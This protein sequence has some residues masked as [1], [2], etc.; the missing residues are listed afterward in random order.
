[1]ADVLGKRNSDDSG[2]NNIPKPPVP[3]NQR[4]PIT[5]FWSLVDQLL[6]EGVTREIIAFWLL[7]LLTMVLCAA[8]HM[9][10][11]AHT[12]VATSVATGTTPPVT[13]YSFEEIKQFLQLVLTPLI[14]L[15]SAATGFYFGSQSVK[16]SATPP[17]TAPVTA[18]A[19]PPATAT[20]TV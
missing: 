8:F 14:T 19:P 1:M 18:P 10:S 4:V 5:G 12:A 16:D 20:G 3:V 7:A 2:Q 6:S 17:A 9:M 15:V 11:E 13:K